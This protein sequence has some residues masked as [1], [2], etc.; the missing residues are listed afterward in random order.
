[1]KVDDAL[2]EK[3]EREERE[4]LMPE[5]RVRRGSNILTEG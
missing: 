5:G 4:D 3:E 2:R 1:M